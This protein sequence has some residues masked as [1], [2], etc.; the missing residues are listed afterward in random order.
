MLKPFLH[1]YYLLTAQ[2]L[3]VIKGLRELLI[4][5]EPIIDEKKIFVQINLRYKENL[6]DEIRVIHLLPNLYIQII[7]DD[8]LPSVVSESPSTSRQNH[9]PR[10]LD[11]Q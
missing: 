1:E 7:C 11:Q 4:E 2:R 3:I 10:T 6:N 9:F 8:I 5:T